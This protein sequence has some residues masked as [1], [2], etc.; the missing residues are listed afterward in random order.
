MTQFHSIVE[1]YS[2]FI[3]KVHDDQAMGMM[4]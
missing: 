2:F 1:V 4:G 3:N